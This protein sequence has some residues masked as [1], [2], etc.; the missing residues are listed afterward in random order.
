MF[1]V[2]VALI[3]TLLFFAL[4]WLGVFASDAEEQAK[5]QFQHWTK[6]AEAIHKL[7]QEE[8]FAEARE[9]LTRFAKDFSRSKLVKQ[10][11][12]AAQID[13]LSECLM[14]ADRELTRVAVDRKKVNFSILRMRLAFDALS[15]ENQ[16]LWL[17]YQD[18]LQEILTDLQAGIMEK[19]SI[20]MGTSVNRLVETFKLIQ[21]ALMM[22]RDATIVNKVE[23]LIK[24]VHSEARRP[25]TLQ[26]N[27]KQLEP[28]L[29][30]LFLDSQ[31][32]LSAPATPPPMEAFLWIGGW[33]T[34][35]LTYVGWRKYEGDRKV[36]HRRSIESDL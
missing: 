35:V 11:L 14:D 24:K 3:V 10:E 5:E 36:V 1:A 6:Q 28:A 32:V 21:P 9:Q 12:T 23:T 20:Q 26:G 29:K 13:A 27:I 15:H 2:R 33:I 25:E 19:D 17:Q 4:S 18:V 31:R 16:P 7:V 8:R 34:A 22:D 30:Q